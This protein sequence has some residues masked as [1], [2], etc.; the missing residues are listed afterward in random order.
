MAKT[1]T[2]EFTDAQWEVV[3]DNYPIWLRDTDEE[4]L[5]VENLSSHIVRELKHILLSDMKLREVDLTSFK[6]VFDE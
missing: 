6:S 2:I 1:V 4:V 3:K 5:T